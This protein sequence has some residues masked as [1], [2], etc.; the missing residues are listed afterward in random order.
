MVHDDM[1]MNCLTWLAAALLTPAAL[2]A[3]ERPLDIRAIELRHSNPSMGLHEQKIAYSLQAASFPAEV[4]RLL[5]ETLVNGKATLGD[6]LAALQAHDAARVRA[7][8]EAYAP[9]ALGEGGTTSA[10]VFRL[11]DGTVL[12]LDDL[13][14]VRLDGYYPSTFQALL[15]QKGSKSVDEPPRSSGSE[16][17]PL[18][19]QER[20]SRATVLPDAPPPKPA[21]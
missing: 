15:V 19:D 16:L 9:G 5:A 7:I 3:P 4:Q 18:T 8:R 13:R 10:L 21:R 14:A 6:Y 2:A 20:A 11:G 1:R 17:T 12:A